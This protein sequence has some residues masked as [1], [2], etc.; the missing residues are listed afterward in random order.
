MKRKVVRVY[1]SGGMEYAKNEGI[2]WRK[3]I[4]TW[5]RKNLSHNIFNPNIESEKYLVKSLPNRNFRSLKS[6]DI[7][8]YTKIVEKFVIIDSKEIAMRSDY[9]ICYWDQ[10]AQRGAGTKGEL[11]IAR[12]FN[13]P[14]YMVTRIPK[15]RIPGWVL[16][17]VTEFFNSFDQLKEFLISKYLLS[18]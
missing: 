11:T 1:L 5:I 6:T 7:K 2:D 16:G 12:Y 15:E 18:K 10:S 8:A 14:V 4:D 13:K 3:D 17:C 9:V